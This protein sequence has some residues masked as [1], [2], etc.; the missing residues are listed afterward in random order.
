[1]SD[2]RYPIWWSEEYDS[3]WDRIRE[4]ARRDWEQT[5]HDFGA[6]EPDLHQ[7]VGDTLAQAAGRRPI[8]PP[9]VATAEDFEPAYRFGYG[10][11]IEYGDHYDAWN[12]DVEALMKEEWEAM[13]PD[14][15]DSW[16]RNRRIVRAGWTYHDLQL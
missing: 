3:A 16:A 1:M 10:A 12:D 14:D 13:E 2:Q 4:A 15:L 7:G 11:R 6:D 5:K 9:G 8:P